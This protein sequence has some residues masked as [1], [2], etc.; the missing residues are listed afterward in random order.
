[1][2]C[3]ESRTH[4]TPTVIVRPHDT[5][6]GYYRCQFHKYTHTLAK[7]SNIELNDDGADAAFIYAHIHSVSTFVNVFDVSLFATRTFGN[8]IHSKSITKA[9]PRKHTN[10]EDQQQQ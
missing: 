1:M 4:H 9:K 7:T 6:I 2:Q 5:D 3:F 8:L 10:N